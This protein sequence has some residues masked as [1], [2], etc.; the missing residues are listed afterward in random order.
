GGMNDITMKTV[1]L[2]GFSTELP[3]DIDPAVFSLV[4][5]A[6]HRVRTNEGEAHGAIFLLVPSGT[7]LDDVG[8]CLNDSGMTRGFLSDNV[9]FDH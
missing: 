2:K 6:A 4:L 5:A 1:P 9:C 7:D 8:Y 3:P